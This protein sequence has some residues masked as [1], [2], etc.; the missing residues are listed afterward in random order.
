LVCLVCPVFWLNETNQ[1]SQINQIHN[2]NQI[3][4]SANLSRLSQTY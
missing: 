4:P 2:T 3:N 1:M